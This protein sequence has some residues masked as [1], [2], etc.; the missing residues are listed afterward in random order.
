[1]NMV[2]TSRGLLIVVALA[3]LTFAGGC[4][5]VDGQF[6][7]KPDGSVDAWM[8]M[9]VLKSM[10]QQSDE[11][12][13]TEV[14]EGLVE[15]RWTEEEPFDRGQWRITPMVGHAGPGESLFKKDADP[16][17]Q[18]DVTPHLLSTTYSFTMPLPEQPVQAEGE[19]EGEAAEGGEV[20]EGAGEGEAAE[21]EGG[22]VQ[23]EGMEGLDEAL[24]DMMG[25]MMTSGDSGVRFSVELPGEIVETNG[26][27]TG[28]SRAAWAIDMAAEQPPYEQMLARSRLLNW[29]AIGRLG[30]ELTDRGRWDLVPALIGGVRR[31]VIPNPAGEEGAEAEFDV[32]MYIQALEIMVHLDRAVGQAIANDV[33]TTLGLGG[34]PDPA[35]IEEIA[36]RLEGMD[37]EAEIDEEVTE[38]LLGR[39]GGG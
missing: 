23:V 29:P 28:Q 16:Q 19:V 38:Q 3:A 37:L 36:V 25:M 34:E 12:P 6:S 11:E 1:M 10:V 17:P 39:L 26:E 15:E 9:G 4:F 2:S 24:G 21:G 22:E 8:E 7:M 30:G 20:A 33:M 13:T 35:M 5:F 14:S 18:F 27:V 32:T 31:G